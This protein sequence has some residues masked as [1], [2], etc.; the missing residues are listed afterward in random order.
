[1][2]FFVNVLGDFFVKKVKQMK[3]MKNEEG[4]MKNVRP[5]TEDTGYTEAP[6]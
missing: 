5:H 1:L 4:K 2:A 6:N 3:K